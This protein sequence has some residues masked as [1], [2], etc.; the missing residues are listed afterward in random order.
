VVD[1]DKSGSLE[2]EFIFDKV[3][4]TSDFVAS[5]NDSIDLNIE[6]TVVLELLLDLVGRAIE[7]VGDDSKLP[8]LELFLDGNEVE[9]EIKVENKVDVDVEIDDK[10]EMVEFK[11]RYDEDPSSAVYQQFDQRNNMLHVGIA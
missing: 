7:I 4:A 5:F 11:K 10:D 3:W 9:D 8:K 2:L 6:D 1:V